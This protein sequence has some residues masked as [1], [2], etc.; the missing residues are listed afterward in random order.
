MCTRKHILINCAFCCHRTPKLMRKHRQ[1]ICFKV[2]LQSQG[3][4]GIPLKKSYLF[5]SVTCIVECRHSS[6]GLGDSNTFYPKP[7]LCMEE[8]IIFRQMFCQVFCLRQMLFHLEKKK[9]VYPISYWISLVAQ[10]LR[11]HLK[12][13]RCRRP[14]FD[15]WRR[16]W[17]PTAVFL[18]V[19]SHGQ[20]SQ[21]GYSPWGR[22]RVR[23]D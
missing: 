15:P 1:V 7:Q 11:I 22:K 14:R 21:E 2:Q 5:Q 18:D 23:K 12:C 13:R 3:F 20:R 17:Q 10:W 9:L 4:S 6:S 8:S 16:K 19:E